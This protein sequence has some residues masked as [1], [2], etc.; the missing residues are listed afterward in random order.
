MCA[1]R[2]TMEKPTLRPI[3]S[4]SPPATLTRESSVIQACETL[5][6]VH[7]AAVVVVDKQAILDGIF[8][9]SDV[10]KR[11]VVARRDPIITTLAALMT[12]NPDFA[13]AEFTILES[14]ERMQVC[15]FRHLSVVENHTRVFVGLVDVLHLEFSAISCMGTVVNEKVSA[16]GSVNPPASARPVQSC[17]STSIFSS[18][19]SNPY[20]QEEYEDEVQDFQPALPQPPVPATMAVP[21]QRS[22]P[23]VHTRCQYSS[24]ENYLPSFGRYGG[25][26]SDVTL[27]FAGR[28]GM[29]WW[30]GRG[31]GWQI[32]TMEVEVEGSGRG[33]EMGELVDGRAGR[34]GGMEWRW[35]ARAMARAMARLQHDR[36]SSIKGN[37]MRDLQV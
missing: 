16:H 8:T 37:G 32:R 1:A 24:L 6:R 5:V 23:F 21:Y 10:F 2:A 18:L 25:T 26:P 31:R 12:S 27:V 30:Q 7:T 17:G 36:A 4:I 34:Y 9:F 11:V 22:H 20:A 33:E 15:G 13:A 19:S 29:M 3:V 28:N 35:L 14:L